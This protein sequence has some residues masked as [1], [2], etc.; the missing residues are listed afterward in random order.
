MGAHR[1]LCLV[2]MC[3]EP[4]DSLVEVQCLAGCMHAKMWGASLGLRAGWCSGTQEPV[5]QSCKLPMTVAAAVLLNSQLGSHDSPQGWREACSWR[6][7]APLVG[8][9]Y[10]T[11]MLELGAAAAE[12]LSSSY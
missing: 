5:V 6:W 10:C 7:M 4:W 8:E 3:E 12:G 11:A 1:E 2:G 9:V